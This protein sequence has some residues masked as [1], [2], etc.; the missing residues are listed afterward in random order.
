VLTRI[1]ATPVSRLDPFLPDQWK[2]RQ[3][4]TPPAN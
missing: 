2:T 4:T 3:T 1:A